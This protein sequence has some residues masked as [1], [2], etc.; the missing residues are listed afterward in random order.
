MRDA[1]INLGK[2]IETVKHNFLTALV[3][4]IAGEI[5]AI[6]T[7]TRWPTAEEI[8]EI[9]KRYRGYGFQFIEQKAMT[10]EDL[11]KEIDSLAKGLKLNKAG[12]LKPGANLVDQQ[13]HIERAQDAARR[14]LEREKRQHGH[15]PRSTTDL[16]E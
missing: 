8:V 4:D 7:L 1:V 9:G 2:V 14:R 11:Q 10:A 16:S 5:R 3:V 12:K 13:G 15:T 6:E